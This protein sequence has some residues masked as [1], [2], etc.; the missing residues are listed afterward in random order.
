MNEGLSLQRTTRRQSS[1]TLLWRL[2]RSQWRNDANVI[3]FA[4]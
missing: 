1:T 4:K 3:A 2:R